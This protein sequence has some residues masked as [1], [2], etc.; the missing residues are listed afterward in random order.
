[1]LPAAT[2]KLARRRA[3]PVARGVPALGPGAGCGGGWGTWL[4]AARS[5]PN[6]T[7]CSVAPSLGRIS[8]AAPQ[9]VKG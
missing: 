9:V 2:G 8:K 3:S 1:M 6:G 7:D 4:R 5:V